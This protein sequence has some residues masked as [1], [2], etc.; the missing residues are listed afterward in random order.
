MIRG[1]K[2][3]ALKQCRIDREF[4]LKNMGKNLL[5][6]VIVF[7]ILSLRL[8]NPISHL[9]EINYGSKFPTNVQVQTI[10]ASKYL[11]RL[12]LYK[13][14]IN[15]TMIHNLKYENYWTVPNFHF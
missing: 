10:L 14:K 2:G 8:Q 5:I 7:N 12:T 3:D 13:A 4:H 1:Q 9:V 15:P 11:R 6:P